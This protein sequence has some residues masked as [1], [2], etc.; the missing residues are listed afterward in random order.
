MA[1]TQTVPFS[2]INS[3]Y[4]SM[5]SLLSAIAC[6]AGTASFSVSLGAPPAGGFLRWSFTNLGSPTG[7]ST[8]TANVSDFITGSFWPPSYLLGPAASVINTNLNFQGAGS[9]PVIQADELA[10]LMVGMMRAILALV[11]GGT[12]SVPTVQ[13]ATVPGQTRVALGI[14]TSILVTNQLAW[15]ICAYVGDRFSLQPV[16]GAAT[17]Q[18]GLY[19]LSTS[20]T[21]VPTTTSSSQSLLPDLDIGVNN[22]SSLWC[23][24]SNTIVEP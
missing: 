5:P 1:T 2:N 12:T 18:P 7:T 6:Q 10:F 9:F 13:S 14:A 21:F 8:I 4:L 22:G 16:G 15:P 23:V 17:N 24:T 20:A 11:V 19:G 3:A